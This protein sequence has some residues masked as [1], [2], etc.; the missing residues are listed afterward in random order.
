LLF[1]AG[2]LIAIAMSARTAPAQLVPN[3]T[4]RTIE[5]RH[6]R[7]HFTPPLEEMARRTAPIA[8]RAFE[9]LSRELKPP[10]GK[11]DLTIADNVDYTNGYATPFPSNRI[12]IFAHP[13]VDAMAL[14]NYADWSQLVVT[15]E[16]THIFHLS[17]AEGLWKVGRYLFGRHPLF[18][19]NAFMP[20]WVTEGLAVYYES[21]LTG[22]GRLEGSEHYMV[23]H[24]AAEAGS[25]PRLNEIS[26]ATSRF[27]GGEVVYA[28]GGFIF[29]YLSQTHGSQSIPH[30][31]DV[32]SKSIF[33]ITL[34]G[35]SKKAF[36][37]S[38]ERAWKQW[39]DSL[40]RVTRRNPE[41]IPGWRQ[42]TPEGWVVAAPRWL[43]DSTLLYGGSTGREVAQAY[44]VN[45][46]GVET[47][48]GRRNGTAANVPLPNGDLLFSQPDFMDPFRLR[49]DLYVQHGNDQIRLTRGARLWSPDVRRDG[50][51]IAVQNVPASSRLVRVSSDGKN[52]SP[53]TR[54]AIDEQWLDP[55]W[56]P[57]GA[58]IAAIRLPRGNRAELVVIDTL[59]AIQFSRSFPGAVPGTPSWSRDGR[60]IFFSSDHTG[61]MQLY[62]LEVADRSGSITRLSDAV[63]GI[64]DPESSPG[65]RWIAANLYRVDGYHLGVAPIPSLS[66]PDTVLRGN[67]ESCASCR[68]ADAAQYDA[69]PPSDAIARGYSPWRSLLPTYW[70]P[71]V[72]S[73]TG[74]GTLLGA[75]TSG[76]DVIGIHS[77]AV[78]AT[79]GTKF[80]EGEGFLAYRYSGLGQPY[81]DASAE[82][83]W[84]HFDI[85][86]TDDRVVGGFS[87]RSRIYSAGMT[88]VRPRVRTSAS[89]SL[90]GEIETRNYSTDP[91][92]LL[93]H[94]GAVFR[95]PASYPS[96]V[97]TAA[98]TNT[99][100]PALAISREDG[101]A[102]S[103]SARERWR[104][105]A[106][107]EGASNKPS[108]AI[109]GT[110]AAFKALDLPGFAHHVIALRG[111][112]GYTDGRTISTFSAGGLSG[113]SIEVLAGYGVGD[114]RR[115]FGV[116]GFPPSAER[117]IRAFAGSV[118]Y[119]APIAAPS[120]HIRFIPLLFDRISA[121]AFADA[122]RAYCP[123]SAVDKET[124]C[125]ESA[126]QNPWLSSVG[127]EL[128]LDAALYYVVPARLRFGVAVPTS[129][130]DATRAKS[131]S[132]YLTFGSSF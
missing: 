131:A 78:Q 94:L 21:R 122:G 12:V 22:T 36:G 39:T 33:P 10:R 25:F 72:E 129:G 84:D 68:V 13:P 51:I 52:I 43:N 67:R 82:Q 70:E 128:N 4:W 5:T 27:P 46:S 83:I 110:T 37:I 80:K 19:P 85:V 54:G 121:S 103:L 62:S 1:A 99:R 23:A 102:V 86:N 119:R 114:T 20:S 106:T 130:R 125:T 31:V 109:V 118:E 93:K 26:E 69:G 117:G 38:F 53:I 98:W 3:D 56:S 65:S 28:Y 49:N 81:V 87:Q 108:H 55:R 74:E 91:D 97:A 71:I 66:I 57:D 14:R 40:I 88:F 96:V 111:A 112:A 132:F 113:T 124:V 15:H 29:D 126:S 92:T 104:T 6:F 115:T 18:F 63:T 41:P 79:Y 60:R 58:R 59:G 48:I 107:E 50:S 47:R 75:A 7:I 44:A 42:L 35:K 24:A 2:A 32:T 127:A 77:Y 89:F 95:E 61:R 30:F 64:F 11:V 8:E 76:T 116:R 73:S 9:Q 101:I 120:R 45:L 100:R 105:G 17:R 16:L 123:T 90:G 34:A